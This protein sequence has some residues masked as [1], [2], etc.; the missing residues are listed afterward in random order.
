MLLCLAW[1]RMCFPS[2]TIY[3]LIDFYPE[4]CSFTALPCHKDGINYHNKLSH[5]PSLE[6][7]LSVF[8]KSLIRFFTASHP[9]DDSLKGNFY[10]EHWRLG[11]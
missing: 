7:P 6:K 3:V 8:L 9:Q 2:Q 5:S 4:M 1:Q 10:S 11:K